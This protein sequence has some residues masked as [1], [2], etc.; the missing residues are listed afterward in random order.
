MIFFL[1]MFI[2]L[3]LVLPLAA[4]CA[5]IWSGPRF[6]VKKDVLHLIFGALAGIVYSGCGA[7]FVRAYRLAPYSF[8]SNW[9]YFLLSRTV[10]PL[11]FIS[12]LFILLSRSSLSERLF[13]LPLYCAGFFMVFMPYQTIHN[14]DSFDFFLLFIYPL[15][16][17]A[18]LSLLWYALTLFSQKKGVGYGVAAVAL[19]AAVL[20]PSLLL[21][22]YFIN[23]LLWLRIILGLVYAGIAFYVAIL[24]F[25]LKD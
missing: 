15:L 12:L 3:L 18:M 2:F 24:S 10:M 22:L 8:L 25:P 5:I 16:T 17:L 11:V 23:S 4:A 13:S 7:L 14:N 9:G 20:M 6:S 21:T 19:I 1:H